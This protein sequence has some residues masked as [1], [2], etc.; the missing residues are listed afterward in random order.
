[1]RRVIPSCAPRIRPRVLAYLLR[2][3]AV[4]ILLYTVVWVCLPRI[5]LGIH[6]VSDIV[7]GIVIGNHSDVGFD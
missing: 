5:Y 7:V 1:M 2:R 3:Y 6:Y 4:T